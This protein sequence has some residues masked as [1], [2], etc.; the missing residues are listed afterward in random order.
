MP[1]FRVT[2]T[3]QKSVRLASDLE[4][5]SQAVDLAE[6][7]NPGW[8]ASH[9]DRMEGESYAERHEVIA[10]CEGCERAMFDLSEYGTDPD[11]I[12]ICHAC[13]KD[14][15]DEECEREAEDAT[16]SD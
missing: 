11:G 7:I 9:V 13:A 1:E 8:R 3:Y 5:P 4:S 6:R 16:A 12:V 10:R 14:M 2:L 15:V